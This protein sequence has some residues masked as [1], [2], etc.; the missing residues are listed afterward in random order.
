MDGVIYT[1]QGE[2]SFGIHVTSP[3]D[4]FCLGCEYCQTKVEETILAAL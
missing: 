1:S 2:P 3:V 4:V